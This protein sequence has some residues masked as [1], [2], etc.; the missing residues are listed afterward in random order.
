MNRQGL[1]ASNALK[2][3]DIIAKELKHISS[4]KSSVE[5]QENSIE[6]KK[7]VIKDNEQSAEQGLRYVESFY[8]S[9]L[10]PSPSEPKE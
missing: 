8:E 4:L 1:K 2:L 9:R 3:Q 7:E 5:R 10:R 6:K